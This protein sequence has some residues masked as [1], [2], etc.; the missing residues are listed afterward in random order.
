MKKLHPDINPGLPQ[1]AID[2]WNQIQKAYS[3]QEWDNVKFLASL[4]DGVVSGGVDFEAS[5]DGM[6]ALKESCERLAAKSREIAKETEKVKSTVPFTYE[7]L[8]EDEELVA[9]RRRQLNAQIAALE[10]C[11]K[12][13][14]ELWNNGK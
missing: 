4:V 5:Q 6:A 9:Q 11:V 3:E 2:L 8:L 12:E 10:E 14:E 13:Y 7:V 1:S